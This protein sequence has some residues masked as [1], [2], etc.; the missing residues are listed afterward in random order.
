M[1]IA[2]FCITAEGTKHMHGQ[3]SFRFLAEGHKMLPNETSAKR[4]V[5]ANSSVILK[6][7]M[8]LCV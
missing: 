2:L 6:G 4:A 1:R 3:R 5:T 7:H 8:V